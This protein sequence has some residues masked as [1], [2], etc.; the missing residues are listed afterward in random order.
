MLEF[1]SGKG[2]RPNT[3]EHGT[4]NTKKEIQVGA[5]LGIEQ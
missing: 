4:F 1:F 3:P 2:S 5:I